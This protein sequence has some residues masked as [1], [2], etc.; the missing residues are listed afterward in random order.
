MKIASGEITNKLMLEEVGRGKE[1]LILSTG[2]SNMAEIGDALEVLK[3]Q[4]RNL[5]EIIVLHCNTE[6][7][8]PIHDMNLRAMQSIAD[9]Y[10]VRVGLSDHSL[11]TAASVAAVA[12]GAELIEKH[13]TLDKSMPGPDHAASMTPCEFKSMV[14]DIRLVEKAIGSDVKEPTSSETKN[15]PIAR[16]SIH[17]KTRLQA[18]HVLRREDMV[19][20]RPGTGVTPMK[21][22]DFVGQVLT[23]TVSEHMMLEQSHF[24]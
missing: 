15:I 10:G 9:T 24:E 7:P 20:L 14:S 6:Y 21:Y 11:G 5:S 13:I 8:T 12:L 16:K 2:M 23:C 3:A 17:Y 4:G 18:S 19:M 22:P 1:P